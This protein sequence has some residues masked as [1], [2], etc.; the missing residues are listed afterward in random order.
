MGFG[1]AALLLGMLLGLVP[2][3]I[4]L[5]NKRRARLVRFSAIEFL[6]LSDK[7]LARRLKLKQ[8]MV[9]AL[10][11]LLLV[12]M[13]FALAKP[14]LEPETT[15]GVDVSE[16]GAVALVIDDSASMNARDA[17]GRSR[18]ER[19]MEEASRLVNQRGQRTS[20]AIITSGAPARLLTPGLSFDDA[21]LGAALAKIV[22]GHRA[23]DFDGA[24]REAGR[25]LSESG[26]ARRQVLVLSDQAN[27]MWGQTP[28]TWTW[29]P[30][31]DISAVF[32]AE[33]IGLPNIAVT[34]VRMADDESGRGFVIE[35]DIV[36]HGPEA[37]SVMVK[38]EVGAVTASESVTVGPGLKEM[39]TFRGGE[40]PESTEGR[41]TIEESAENRLADD[42]TWFFTATERTALRVLLINGAPRNP[43][44]LDELY[45]LRPALSVTPPGHPPL[46]IASL[47]PQDVG[48]AQ[49]Q[50]A[51]VVVLANVGTLSKEQALALTHFVEAGGGLL[52][53]AGDKIDPLKTNES[54]G[55][56]LPFRIREIKT[57]GRAD[58]P[59][60]VLQALNLA[61]V[62]FDHPVFAVFRGLQDSSLFKARVTAWALVDTEGNPQAK[63]LASLTGGVP[64]L[65]EAPLGRGR[66][67]LWTSSID[68]D[69]TDLVL[70]TS[71]PPLVQRMAAWLGRLL[72]RESGG[73]AASLGFVVGRSGRLPVPDGIGPVTVRRPDG[74]ELAFDA[75]EGSDPAAV[76]EAVVFIETIDMAGH[77]VVMRTGDPG[78]TKVIAA[79]TD[80]RESDLA[81]ADEATIVAASAVLTRDNGVLPA[82][83]NEGA[84]VAAAGPAG[85]ESSRTVLWPWILAGLFLL[86]GSEAW[87]LIRN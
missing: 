56:L 81:V 10:R 60:S 87:L 30:L 85:S 55:A 70:R 62:D 61:T 68:R 21:A 44:W 22:P 78:R 67:M 31:S 24:L 36:N 65:V 72:E 8:I 49:L 53:T 32:P 57:V 37:A 17:D 46:T 63:V 43:G 45:F 11:V 82:F 15:A 52:V 4:H 77:W 41:V 66:V 59:Q 33:N 50:A 9:L 58:D 75:P 74:T 5:I 28:E 20:V 84:E 79:N 76:G 3:I 2:I 80:R 51:D 39:A 27:H 19:V 14:Y 18:F 47:S 29:A 40:K 64:A 13:A 6:L 71:F 16:P 1:N 42:D 69:W 83:D 48:A 38:L 7:K 35:A 54:Y 73:E 26:E 86:F 12:A 23:Q 25:V 34:G